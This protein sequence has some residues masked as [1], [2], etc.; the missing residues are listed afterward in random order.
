MRF[1]IVIPLYNKEWAIARALQSVFAQTFSNYEVIVVDDGSTDGG[2]AVVEGFSDSRLKL[3]KQDNS[4]VA[5]ARNTGI[6]NARGDIVCFLDG[7]DI[8]EKGHLAEIDRLARKYPEARFYTDKYEVLYRGRPNVTP[9]FPGLVDLDGIVENYA[10]SCSGAHNAV[11][12]SV[13]AVK[14][15]ALLAMKPMFPEGIAV[16]EDLDLWLRLAMRYVLAYSSRVGAYYDRD[17]CDNARTQNRVHCPTAYFRTLEGA[18][19]SPGVPKRWKPYL[20]QI[21]D[22][23][24]VAYIF[25]LI[26]SED[27]SKSRDVM[28]L[29]SPGG[30]YASYKVGL[31]IAQKLPSAAI[32]AVQRLRAKVY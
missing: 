11:H 1:S 14:R 32:I 30:R 5:A 9:H 26:V 19:E 27:R 24:M 10:M 15:D 16:G 13:A 6:R 4:G 7:D 3:I 29:W 2:A 21:Y 22:R 8:W 18:I 23:K 28:R 25:S 12:S 31:L 17:T 20:K